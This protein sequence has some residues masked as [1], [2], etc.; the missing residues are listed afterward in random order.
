[1]YCNAHNTTYLRSN[2]SSDRALMT[3]CKLY[4]YIAFA[5][6]AFRCLVYIIKKETV[7]KVKITPAAWKIKEVRDTAYAYTSTIRSFMAFRTLVFG[8]GTTISEPHIIKQ[9]AHI[10]VLFDI[11]IFLSLLSHFGY[12][13]LTKFESAVQYQS[14]SALYLQLVLVL[15]GILIFV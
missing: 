11:Y 5:F 3:H 9:L 4:I 6:S 7:T 12:F 15:S 10:S 14:K 1:M 13:G 2:K 8:W